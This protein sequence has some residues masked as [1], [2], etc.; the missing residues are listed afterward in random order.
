MAGVLE[1]LDLTKRYRARPRPALDRVTLSV[2]AGTAVALVGP[3]GAGKSTLIRTFLGFERPSGGSVL[4]TGID[5]R[6]NRTGALR[7]IGYVG[8]SPGLYRELNPDD[9]FALAASLRP[10]FDRVA[11]RRRLDDLGIPSR[12]RVGHLSGGQQAQVAL[13]LAIGS[14]APVLLL[15]EP[16]ASLDP[17]A[18]RDFLSVVTDEVRQNGTTV[19]LASHIVGDLAATCDRIVVLAPAR[20]VLDADIAAAKTRHALRS[21]ADAGGHEVVGAFPDAAGELHVLVRSPEPFPDP[22]SLDDVVLGYLAAARP[23]PTSRTA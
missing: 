22:V 18:R 2:E 14:R 13:A 3:N 10:G 16:L 15:D 21:P 5:P 23:G 7:Q 12:D 8:Q 17:L 4:V 1:A 11:A 6:R 19:L 20:V 9:H